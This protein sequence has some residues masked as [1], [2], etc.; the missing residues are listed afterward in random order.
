MRTIRKKP[1]RAVAAAVS[2]A[3]RE[4]SRTI[5]DLSTKIGE[6]MAREIDTLRTA[7][8]LEEQLEGC[9]AKNRE[10]RDELA[11]A[12]EA[13]ATAEARVRDVAALVPQPERVNELADAHRALEATADALSNLA[14]A[15]VRALAAGVVAEQSAPTSVEAA[16]RDALTAAIDFIHDDDVQLTTAET[17]ADAKRLTEMAMELGCKSAVHAERAL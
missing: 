3:R 16:L 12:H 9:F 4:D 17:V 13:K 2:E 11:A 5:F 15:R 14:G 6:L 10:L 8:G 7:V 1:S